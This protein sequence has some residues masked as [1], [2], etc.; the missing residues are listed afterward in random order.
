MLA[1]ERVICEIHVGTF[2]KAGTFAGAS[3]RLA[4]LR[5]KGFTT[6]QLMPVDVSTG[7]PGWTYDQTRTGAVAAVYG[8]AT[9]LI[10]FVEKAHEHGLEVI[11]D[12]QYNHRAP[13]Q[14]SRPE[15]ISGM[16]GRQTRWGPGLSGSETAN[17]AQILK[18]IGEELWYWAWQFGIDG[19]RFDATNRLPWEIHERLAEFGRQ[20]SDATGK[21]LYLLSEYAECEEPKGKR[22]PTG[23]QYTDQAGRYLMKMFELSAAR[24][25][26]ELPLDAGSVLRPLLAAARRGWWYPDVPAPEPSLYG[27][28]RATTLLC[29]HD[30][31]GN[32]FRGERMASLAS[33]GLFKTLAVW[34]ALGQWTPLLF[35]GTERYAKT[36]W[37]Y[38]TGHQDES[39][40][41]NTSAFYADQNG[42]PILCGGRFHEFAS[43]ARDDGLKDALAFS[44]NG[45]IASI[46]WDE[47]RRQTDRFGR[48]YMDHSDQRTFEASKLDWG[49]QDSK[50]HA[51]Q[52]LF[53]TVLKARRD[54]RVSETDPRHTQYKAW[55]KSERVFVMRRRCGSGGELLVC[56]NLGDK[57]VV[58]R[59]ADERIDLP[60]YGEG[61]IVASHESEREQEWPNGGEYRLWLDTN[62]SHYGGTLEGQMDG[63]TISP[64]SSAEINLPATT[65]LAFARDD[66]QP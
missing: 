48:L 56:F 22:V 47:F 2:T 13:E 29:H 9:G 39:S 24:H 57:P 41:N 58:I 23:H 19:F 46:N 62:A 1:G 6:L 60:G 66:P 28:E 4:Y 5:D 32:R 20:I 63:F 49:N 18:L 54:P 50:G 8:G 7:S 51:I 42:R 33:F 21:P 12:K 36:P 43:E 15:I 52:R 14:D 31:I 35:M 37:Y 26:R 53:E 59:I 25:V 16:F 34:Q 38:F 65:A 55:E 44:Q 40:R 61:Y 10:E 30:W 3:E 17:Y 45:T 64:A 27:N 11:L